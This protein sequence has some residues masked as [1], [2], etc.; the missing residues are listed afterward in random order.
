MRGFNVAQS[1]GPSKPTIVFLLIAVIVSGLTLLSNFGPKNLHVY[2]KDGS[3]AKL[4]DPQQQHQHPT[5]PSTT[6]TTTTDEPI[7]PP[8]TLLDPNVKYLSYLP[9]AGLT[10]QFIALEV[11]MYAAKLLNR[12]LIIPPIVSNTHDTDNTHQRWSRYFDMP[13][14][15][16]LTGVPVAEWDQVRPLTPAQQQVGRDQVTMAHETGSADMTEEWSKLAQNFTCHIV[17]GYGSRNELNFS[18][19]IFAWHFMM[20][21]NMVTPPPLKPGMEEYDNVKISNSEAIQ[22]ELVVVQDL[23][24]RYQDSEDQLLLLSNSY[25]LKDPGH[26]TKRYWE[27]MGSKLHFVPQLMEYA[28]I[29]I[30]KELEGDQ[31]ILIVPNDDPE[32]KDDPL[33]NADLD[34]KTLAP[35]TPNLNHDAGESGDL[36]NLEMGSIT[37][38]TTR[39]PHIAVHFRRGDIGAKCNDE[40][41]DT[42]MIPFEYYS[43]A[44][45]RAR[46][47]AATRGLTAYLPVVVTT[48][49]KDENDYRKIEA[50]G[51]HRINHEKYG[52][53]DLWGSFG[54]AM[55][56][57]AILAHA[58]EFVASGRST[59][60]VVAAARQKSWYNRN[61]VYPGRKM[62]KLRRRRWMDPLELEDLD[63][64]VRI[65]F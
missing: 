60:S 8:V 35:S 23:F 15:T 19:K 63:K 41:M 54:P 2:Y 12:T 24:Q 49:S 44:V 51:W 45:T 56:D 50:A 33:L 30:N 48:D 53:V 1:T 42:C 31:G 10:N 22:E 13:R 26:Y 17:Y 59:M 34:G 18:A 47:V 6:T 61:T 62:R 57:A 5:N 16:N 27:E 39:I 46:M 25:K 32:E 43:D 3:T 9:F 38:P 64:D 58:D 37:A 29:Q 14:F 52:T 7:E 28:T 20:R 40:T 55:V 36:K 4:Q 11:A 65:V 21:L